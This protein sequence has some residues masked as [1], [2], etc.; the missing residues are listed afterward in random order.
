MSRARR[1]RR[2]GC[3]LSRSR[4][5]A[6]EGPGEAERSRGIYGGAHVA[7]GRRPRC[8]WSPLMFLRFS[9]RLHMSSVPLHLSTHNSILLSLLAA[10]FVLAVIRAA[11]LFLRSRTSL[12]QKKQKLVVTQHQSVE[13]EALRSSS[14]SPSRGWG[15]FRWD[16]LPTL[17]VS[18][19]LN[20]N[21]MKGQ[22]VGFAPPTPPERSAAQPWR[23]AGPAFESPRMSCGYPNRFLFSNAVLSVAAMYQTD[24]P[25]SM[26]KMIMS[27][28]VCSILLPTH[29]DCPPNYSLLADFSAASSSPS[30]SVVETWVTDAVH[31][32]TDLYG[33]TTLYDIV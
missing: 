23:R 28:H 27:R 11:L 13:R 25:V 24:V 29:L 5:P 16:N 26:A 9:S 6:W 1:R 4:Q 21:D 10:V 8:P 7:V 3:R 22:G 31:P 15:C 17:P 18:L 30:T 33:I 20:E 14:P 12:S 32:S 19:K 2:P